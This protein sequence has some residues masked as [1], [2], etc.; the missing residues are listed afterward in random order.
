MGLTCPGR[1]AGVVRPERALALPRWLEDRPGHGDPRQGVWSELAGHRGWGGSSRPSLTPPQ[2]VPGDGCQSEAPVANQNK[3]WLG[4]GRGTVG[5]DSRAGQGPGCGS[6][7]S[8]CAVWPPPS[9]LPSL[10]LLAPSLRSA[11]P[12]LPARVSSVPHPTPWGPSGPKA[13]TSPGH[14]SLLH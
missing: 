6:T 1:G 4:R 3:P 11:H 12:R 9:S 13:M 14:R 2:P 5:G 8:A 7:G 10:S